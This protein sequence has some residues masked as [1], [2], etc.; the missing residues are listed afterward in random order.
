MRMPRFRLL[1]AGLTILL[2]GGA[3]P[4]DA[5]KAEPY[6]GDVSYFAFDFCPRGW[7]KAN[8]ARLPVHNYIALYSVLRNRYGGDDR[9]FNLPDVTGE[10]VSRERGQDVR[11]IPCIALVGI[12]P[13]RPS[14]N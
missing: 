4:S 8:G 13:S 10:V 1:C 11:L 7:T 3:L 5:A 14:D 9:S 2:A 6:I 12:Y